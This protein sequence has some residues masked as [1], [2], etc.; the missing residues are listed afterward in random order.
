MNPVAPG[1]SGHEVD[2]RGLTLSA[3][4][5]HVSRVRRPGDTVRVS[6]ITSHVE[7]DV[8]EELAHERVEVERVPIGRVVDAVPPIREEGDVTIVP[9]VEEEV[10]V[11]KRLILREEVRMRRF[12]HT[13]VHRE[14]VMVRR[15]DVSVSRIPASTEAGSI[16]LENLN[17]K[18]GALNMSDEMI[19][20][21]YDTMAKAEAAIAD[22][23]ALGVP[24]NAIS[25]RSDNFTVDG[26]T[27][28]APARERGFWASLFGGE[29]EHDTAIYD[30]RL[31]AGST[32]VSVRSPE[33]H[34]SHVIEIM[35]KHGPIDIDEQVLG[36][37][38]A[39]TTTTAAM[40]MATGTVAPRPVTADGSG[41]MQLSE[42]QLAVGKRLVNHGGTR[43]HRFV[44]ETPVEENVSLHS[45]KV[46]LE[47]H[48][49]T[50]GR[51]VGD[52]FD[53]R[54][55]EMTESTEEAVVSKTAHVY[56]EVGLRKEASDR[57]ETV[58]DTVRKEEV[59][60]GQIPGTSAATTPLDPR[61]PKI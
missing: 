20:A 48:P 45:E 22:L 21:S 60:I 58:R 39:Q 44:V 32:I 17:S 29:P 40:P 6:T 56:E 18:T 19:V 16:D 46:I 52:S 1:D 34:V 10:V 14:T 50:D 4:A 49:V 41:M 3:E 35:E 9:V 43:I 55:I 28:V 2:R 23:K 42:E 8:E 57:V 27:S 26:Q 37:G 11:M 61:T 30:R 47:R 54:T 7:T 13:S 24:G 53:D 25:K 36:E 5:M 38:I 15:Q 51:P 59:E 31:A 33:A 12:R